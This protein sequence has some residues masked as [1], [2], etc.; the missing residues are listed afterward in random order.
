MNRRLIALALA[1]A[2]GASPAAAAHKYLPPLTG[3][4][5]PGFTLAES[6]APWLPEQLAQKSLAV[7][8]SGN[9]DVSIVDW[10]KNYGKAA[11]DTVAAAIGKGIDPAI[12]VNR[13][14]ALLR[15]HFATMI[16]V[17]DIATARR[18]GVDYIAVLDCDIGY[19]T[20]M[21]KTYQVFR[22]GVMM[23]DSKVARVF[24]VE[25]S[26]EVRSNDPSLFKLD[27]GEVNAVETTGAYTK[28]VEDVAAGLDAK[29]R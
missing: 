8:V 5:P 7:V 24:T 28:M 18:Q 1:V 29:L 22:G 27:F 23:L 2:S 16:V 19:R 4:V 3:L 6:T 15:P 13:T 11:P 25:A 10:K 20:Q 12:F 21:L 17:P 26:N 14:I 9:L